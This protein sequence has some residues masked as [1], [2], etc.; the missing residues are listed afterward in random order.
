MV[1][2]FHCLA[3]IHV[4]RNQ[5]HFAESHNFEL[6]ARNRLGKVS[7]S[8][9]PPDQLGRQG[10]DSLFQLR[11]SLQVDADPGPE[12]GKLQRLEPDR[13]SRRLCKVHGTSNAEISFL[14]NDEMG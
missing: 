6:Q 3:K 8:G 11:I 10:L 12:R 1:P 7:N 5:R 13:V 2:I 9:L 14:P 4:F